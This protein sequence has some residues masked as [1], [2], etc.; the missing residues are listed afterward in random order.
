MWC[1]SVLM[2]G[3][4][5]FSKRSVS[6]CRI[7]HIEN[8]NALPQIV[9]RHAMPP[10]DRFSE[11][12]KLGYEK[13]LLTELQIRKSTKL[14]KIADSYEIFDLGTR[15]PL[16]LLYIEEEVVDYLEIHLKKSK[17]SSERFREMTNVWIEESLIIHEK[18][19]NVPRDV[20]NYD[21]P[22]I[23]LLESSPLDVRKLISALI[24]HNGSISFNDFFPLILALSLWPQRW[25]YNL[26]KSH[27]SSVPRKVESDFQALLMQFDEMSIKRIRNVSL[28]T[29]WRIDDAYRRLALAKAWLYV[30]QSDGFIG[31]VSGIVIKI[32]HTYLHIEKHMFCAHE[33]ASAK[34]WNT[35]GKSK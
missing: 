27:A 18:I 32:L 23:E 22:I 11:I 24:E 19:K 25:T 12:V 17:D 8:I 14:E 7:P 33:Q 34:V 28:K 2:R 5:R 29:S 20:E 4:L 6:T 16:N 13:D 31:P 9:E 3:L 10:P 1:H 30:L 21:D 26:R 15:A 35:R